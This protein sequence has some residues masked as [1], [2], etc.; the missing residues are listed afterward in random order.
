M[1]AEKLS[2]S[3][4]ADMAKMVRSH[5]TSGEYASN[6]ELIRDALRMWQQRDRERADRLES[7]RARIN[8]AAEN[9]ERIS[10]QDM[11]RHFENLTIEAEKKRQAP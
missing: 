7:I 5:V 4:P 9:P 3:L 1:D 10:A 6:S 8:Q 11:R 2:I